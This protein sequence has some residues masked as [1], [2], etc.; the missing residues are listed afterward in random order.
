MVHFRRFYWASLQHRSSFEWLRPY[1]LPWLNCVTDLTSQ[2]PA[3]TFEDKI[4]QKSSMGRALETSG[5]FSL[6]P[7][8]WLFGIVRTRK[9]WPEDPNVI[10]GIRIDEFF[11]FWQAILNI[12]VRIHRKALRGCDEKV[13]E[14]NLRNRHPNKD[15][16]F[17]LLFFQRIW[18]HLEY[19][20]CFLYKNHGFQR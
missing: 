8:N 5:G 4:P 6:Q 3:Y 15:F 11:H 17:K 19:F 14:T 1:R 9:I 2:P 7:L 13:R 16:L 20:E 12:I 10:F 18:L